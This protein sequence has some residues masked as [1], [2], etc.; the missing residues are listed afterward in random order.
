MDWKERPD[1][2]IQFYGIING[3]LQGLG[4]WT[5]ELFSLAPLSERFSVAQAASGKWKLLATT[6][7]RAYI[8]KHHIYL[9]KSHV[10]FHTLHKTP[11]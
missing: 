3:G 2:Q 11:F 4:R 7:Q 5:P 8:E 10:G 9:S 6:G 1:L